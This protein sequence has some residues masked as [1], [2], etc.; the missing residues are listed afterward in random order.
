MPG[1]GL[2]L[3]E[4]FNELSNRKVKYCIWKGSRNIEETFNG[5]R[6][7]DLLV[8]AHQ[9]GEFEMILLSYGFKK[10]LSPSWFTFPGIED[11]IGLDPMRGILIHLHLYYRILLGEKYVKEQYIPMEQIIL[12][13]AV[14]HPV[15][16]LYMISIEQA[17]VLNMFR[18]CCEIN[19]GDYLKGK[20]RGE[21]L[22]NRLIEER[23]EL[24]AQT[25]GDDVICSSKDL[26]LLNYIKMKISFLRRMA[27]YRRFN[28]LLAKTMNI[29]YILLR[30]CTYTLNYLGFN[31]HKKKRLHSGGKII[32]VIGCDGSGKTTVVKKL[33]GWLCWKIDVKLFYF[34]SNNFLG[35][36]L[37]YFKSI[38]LRV[39]TGSYQGS[40]SLLPSIESSYLQCFWRIMLARQRLS[41][42]LKAQRYR[43]NGGIVITDRYPQNQ[44][45]GIYDGPALNCGEKSAYIKKIM[46]NYEK[47]IY[48]RIEHYNPDILVKLVVSPELAIL[49]KPDHKAHIITEK[50]RLIHHLVCKEA[51]VINIDANMPIDEVLKTIKK[52]IWERL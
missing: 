46:V 13:K 28:L 37:S 20:V 14:R 23:E 47:L 48:K 18:I 27:G 52:E 49:R 51:Y 24:M 16:A 17:A 44:F 31:C 19:I 32:A 8:C 3:L 26:N 30:V 40:A 6:D 22:I 4:V 12:E 29:Y 15:Y 10:V 9:A 43:Q 35:K 38:L 7:L 50:A 21:S 1:S 34:G 11:W 41:N 42:V 33:Y 5:Q 39:D 36:I 25:N 2:F 45:R